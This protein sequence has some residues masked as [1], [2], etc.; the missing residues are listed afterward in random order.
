MSDEQVADFKLAAIRALTPHA[1]AVLVDR[2]FAWK[3]TVAEQAT[4][5]AC[6]LIAAADEFIPGPDELVGDVRIDEEMKPE[7][8]R[9]QGAAAM[10][11]LML[12]R[13]DEPAGPRIAMV[14]DF[15]ARCREAGLA[16]IIEPISRKP[17]REQP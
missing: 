4:D 16:S 12:W 6:G 8:V 14:R 3:R 15:V 11:L 7:T 17:R 13:P 2:Q 5:P 9:E 10:K 1:S